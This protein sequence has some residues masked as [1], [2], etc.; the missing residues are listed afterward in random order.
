MNGQ[1][2]WSTEQAV[3]WHEQKGEPGFRRPHITSLPSS[4]MAAINPD[5]VKLDE[6]SQASGYV[7][8]NWALILTSYAEGNLDV[9]R[10]GAGQGPHAVQHPQLHEHVLGQVRVHTPCCPWLA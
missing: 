10:A 7:S 3:G 5:T 1:Q 8:L 4:T 2:G 9:P 6:A